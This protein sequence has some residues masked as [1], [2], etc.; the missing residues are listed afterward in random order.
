MCGAVMS[1]CGSRMYVGFSPN[2]KQCVFNEGT[3][4]L[5]Q[6]WFYD[7]WTVL[8]CG[9]EKKSIRFKMNAG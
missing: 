7:V 4:Q 9:A 2:K 1:I 6:K 5:V 8:L 3:C